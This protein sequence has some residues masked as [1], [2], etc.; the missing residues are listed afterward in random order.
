MNQISLK[1]Y[2]KFFINKDWANAKKV[3]E[4]LL[5]DNL[6]SYWF[7]TSLS[8]VTYE[9][10]DYTE[11]LKYAEIAYSMNPLSPLVLWDYGGALYAL[12]REDEAIFIWKKI[13]ELDDNKIAFELTQ[14]GLKWAVSLKNDCYFRIGEAYYYLENDVLAIENILTHLANRKRGLFSLY[15]KR[16]A[17]NLLKKI[18]DITVAPKSSEKSER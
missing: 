13:L 2:N 15:S 17:L 11:S 1:E 3:L 5:T 4:I 12:D 18:Q 9:L 14:E 10:K 6:D 7:Y 8:S 16:E